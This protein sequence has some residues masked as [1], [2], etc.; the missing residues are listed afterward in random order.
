MLFGVT[1]SMMPPQS[2]PAQEPS[3]LE[4]ICQAMDDRM[5]TQNDAWFGEG[6]FPRCIQTLRFRVIFRPND[7]EAVTDLGWMYGNVQDEK[8]ELAT[9]ERYAKSNSK[10]PDAPFPAANFYFNKKRYAETIRLLGPSLAG[11]P[12]P[13]SYRLLA[14]SY[15]RSGDKAAAIRVWEQYLA[16][17]PED[18]A[19]KKNLERLKKG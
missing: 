11:K 16:R 2:A 7:Y 8:S 1:P 4:A 12:H 19:A 15:D 14:H 10:D 9:Y 3:R 17:F 18:A 13:N 5:V 6:D